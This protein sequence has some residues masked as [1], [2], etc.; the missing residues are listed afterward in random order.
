MQYPHKKYFRYNPNLDTF[1]D[2]KI[3]EYVTLDPRLPLVYKAEDLLPTTFQH[4]EKVLTEVQDVFLHYQEFD[5][6]Q[7][8]DISDGLNED[9]EVPSSQ[10]EFDYSI[11]GYGDADII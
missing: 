3:E 9:D 7:E 2:A 5:L 6:K 4:L 10:P 11:F 8:K 1:G